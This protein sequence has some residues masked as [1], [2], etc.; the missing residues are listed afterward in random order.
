QMRDEY[1]IRKLNPRRNPYAKE[2]KK[3]ISIKIDQNV[4]DYFKELS[5]DNGIPY[6]TL[7]NMY[8]SNCAINKKKP[9]LSWK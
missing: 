8:L 1:E 4:I 7:I 5:S 6:Q 2:T 3:Q 9:D